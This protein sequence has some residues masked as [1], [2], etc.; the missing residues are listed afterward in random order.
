MTKDNQTKSKK[1]WYIRW[2][3]I[4]IYIFLFIKFVVFISD[5]QQTQMRTT[6][7][8]NNQAQE[9]VVV[10]YEIIEEKDISYAGCKRIIINII[11]PDN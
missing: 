6:T 3:A 7:P 10:N 11:V 9:Q 4:L 1:K 5:S 8:I 2:W